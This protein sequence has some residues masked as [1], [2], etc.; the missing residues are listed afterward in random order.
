MI[1]TRN[2]DKTLRI[3]QLTTGNY[4]LSARAFTIAVGR[5]PFDV[6]L[7]RLIGLVTEL[8]ASADVQIELGTIS[9]SDAYFIDATYTG[10]TTTALGTEIITDLNDQVVPANTMIVLRTGVKSGTGELSFLLELEK[11]SNLPQE[12]N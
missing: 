2:V 1:T 7:K 5:F 11:V 6:K 10:S 3:F 12:V 8:F 4:D 9:D